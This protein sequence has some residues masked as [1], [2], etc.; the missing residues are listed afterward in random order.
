LKEQARLRR[1]A[2]FPGSTFVGPYESEGILTG[3]WE[4]QWLWAHRDLIQG[5]V[6][7]MSTPRHYHEF[8]YRLP[9]VEGVLISDLCGEE[10]E[11]FGHR[12]KVDIVGDFC[13]AELPAPEESF[14]TVL[15]LSILEHCED[16]TAMVENIG[17]LLRPGGTAFFMAPFA[18]IDGHLGPDYWRFARDGYLLMARKANL[19]VLE[20]GQFCDVGEYFVS[21][22]GESAAATAHHRGVPVVNWMIC[23]RPNMEQ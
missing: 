12:S 2:E 5:D 11:K 15:C 13:A 17:R 20:T 7:D 8:V 23:R 19:E 4:E 1:R 14:D 10:I 9:A 18:Y 6:L 22:I 3:V 16:P 21:E